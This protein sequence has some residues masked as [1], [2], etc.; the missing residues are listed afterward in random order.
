MLRKAVKKKTPGFPGFYSP[1]VSGRL[2]RGFTALPVFFC[3]ISKRGF[4]IFHHQKFNRQFSNHAIVV[5]D[6]RAYLDVGS[7]AIYDALAA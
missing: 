6:A 2:E 4:P 3:R 1:G 5:R 7:S